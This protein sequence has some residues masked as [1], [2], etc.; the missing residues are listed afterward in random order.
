MGRKEY[1]KPDRFTI[2]LLDFAQLPLIFFLQINVLGQN[3]RLSNNF[4]KNQF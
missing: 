2:L 4:V 3:N 1:G